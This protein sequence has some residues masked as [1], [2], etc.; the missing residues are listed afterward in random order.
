MTSAIV[1]AGGKGTRLHPYT[2]VFPKPMLPIGGVPILETIVRQLQHFGIIKIT[3]SLG[4]MPTIIQSYFDGL[5]D[6]N[7]PEIDYYIEENL[8]HQSNLN[9]V[10][11]VNNHIYFGDRFSSVSIYLFI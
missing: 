10:H 5:K 9:K 4:Y 2:V 8:W 6:D 3:L 7:L 11:V 1:L